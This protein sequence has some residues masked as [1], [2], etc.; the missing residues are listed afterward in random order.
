[1]NQEIVSKA[2]QEVRKSPRIN[3]F[4][5]AKTVTLCR[6]LIWGLYFFF[7]FSY[8]HHQ[9]GSCDECGSKEYTVSSGRRNPLTVALPHIAL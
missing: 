9:N 4:A 7:I 3:S 6:I 1:M 2:L 8:K 5:G